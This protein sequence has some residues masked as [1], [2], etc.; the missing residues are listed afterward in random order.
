MSAARLRRST[1]KNI[2]Y[3]KEQDFSDEDLFEDGERPV[4]HTTTTVPAETSSIPSRRKKVRKL[5]G[6][7]TASLHRSASLATTANFHRDDS[8]I[9]HKNKPV[10]M[11]K[12]YD[13]SLPPIRERFSFMPEYED[14]GT[15]KIELIVGRRLVDE[16]AQDNDDIS[17]HDFDENDQS[18]SIG[19]MDSNPNLPQKIKSQISESQSPSKLAR[20][21]TP[22]K[23]ECGSG[24]I[25]EYEY[26]VK[27]KGRSYLH[28]EWK[29]GADL[30]S[31]NKSA[32]GIYRRYL[33]K[34]AQGVDDDL[35]SPEFDPS[36]IVPEKIVDEAEQE[37]TI[38]LTDKELLRWEKQ[39]EKEL[40]LNDGESPDTNTALNNE[41]LTNEPTVGSVLNQERN[42]NVKDEKN[43][44]C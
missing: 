28:L 16:S 13:S 32:K 15:L 8:D 30:E 23:E 21:E 17:N 14:D 10:Y 42:P 6:D 39:K 3:A 31:M 38:E 29:T 35:E 26:L 33:K 44:E 24:P 5:K 19:K 40:G 37:I 43:G 36:Y 20:K 2:N 18:D 7:P 12:G 4:S 41:A 27:Y 9:F 11:E 25:G 1:V 22:N 34:I